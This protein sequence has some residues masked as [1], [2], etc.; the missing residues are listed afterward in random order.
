MLRQN[1]SR[2]KTQETSYDLCMAKSRRNF[3][4]AINTKLDWHRYEWADRKV[5]G[6]I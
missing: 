3:E 2:T 1:V 4:N 6:T 5:S